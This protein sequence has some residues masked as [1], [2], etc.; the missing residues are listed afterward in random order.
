MCVGDLN[1]GPHVCSLNTLIIKKVPFSFIFFI[2]VQVLSHS[3]GVVIR[4]VYW[5][6]LVI[7]C[8]KCGIYYSTN[9]MNFLFHCIK[10]WCIKLQ[11]LIFQYRTKF[12]GLIRIEESSFKK[13]LSER[14]GAHVS[15][16]LYMC[17]GGCTFWK[18]ADS[19]IDSNMT[20]HTVLNVELIATWKVHM[21]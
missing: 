20:V 8:W 12:S 17:L 21:N 4:W 5:V 14:K 3:V 7:C 13:Q 10:N 11:F 2:T 19:A 18:N 1:F 16:R 6:L 9:L 15:G